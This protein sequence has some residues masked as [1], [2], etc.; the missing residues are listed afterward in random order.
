MSAAK[1]SLPSPQLFGTEPASSAGPPRVR[2][3]GVAERSLGDSFRL[4]PVTCP[5]QGVGQPAC[6]P[7]VPERP[8]GHAAH[9]LGEQFGG[10]PGAWPTSDSADMIS[11]SRIHS[12]IGP[13]DRT[14]TVLIGG[15]SSWI[16]AAAIR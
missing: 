8:R 4:C 3:R 14:A 7:A 1:D 2:V 15:T 11:H 12:P 16:A 10:D 9:R 6:Q 13:P 5:E